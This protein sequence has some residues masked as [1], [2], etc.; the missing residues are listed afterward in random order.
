M[1]NRGSYF[2]VFL[3]I[4]L[5]NRLFRYIVKKIIAIRRSICLLIHAS[6]YF[7]SFLGLNFL[8]SFYNLK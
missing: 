1:G 2:L 7:M 3:L 6:C 8:I 4:S 5:V